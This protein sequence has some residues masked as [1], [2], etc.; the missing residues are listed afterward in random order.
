MKTA[1]Y[2]DVNYDY[3]GKEDLNSPKGYSSPLL[4]Q[5]ATWL[6]PPTYEDSTHTLK[7]SVDSGS[8]EVKIKNVPVNAYNK[9]D[10]SVK[11]FED[12]SFIEE[13]YTLIAPTSPHDEW[14]GDSWVLNKNKAFNADIDVLNVEYDASMLALSN[15]YSVAV[16]R[17]GSTETEKVIAVRTRIV[18]LDSEF[19]TNRTN[20]INKYFGV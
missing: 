15:K 14:L 6:P 7:Y 2:F 9:T 4:P 20:L 12:I 10:Q 16:A 8:W 1:Y 11:T 19:E 3:I 17:D 5:M 18:Q 13:G